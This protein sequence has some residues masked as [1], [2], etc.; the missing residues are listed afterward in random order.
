MA[1]LNIVF[2]NRWETRYFW[3]IRGSRRRLLTGVCVLSPGRSATTRRTKPAS[4]WARRPS[5]TGSN[6]CAHHSEVRWLPDNT[7]IG[8]RFVRQREPHVAHDH[9]LHDIRRVLLDWQ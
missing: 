7:E 1:P 6:I 3:D 8:S 4:A 9:K 2:P 5:R